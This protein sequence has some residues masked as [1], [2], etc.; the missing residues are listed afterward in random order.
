MNSAA[1]GEAVAF[2]FFSALGAPGAALAAPVEAA[3]VALLVVF[4][5]A[6][7]GIFFAILGCIRETFWKWSSSLAPPLGVRLLHP[8]P[9][10]SGPRVQHK[11]QFHSV[12]PVSRPPF[13]CVSKPRPRPYTSALGFKPEKLQGHSPLTSPHF[14]LTPAQKQQQHV[15]PG[16]PA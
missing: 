7:A 16:L 13:F 1:S 12:L 15:R 8:F 3:L 9:F 2:P 5:G 4:G 6:F 14:P 11:H 10:Q